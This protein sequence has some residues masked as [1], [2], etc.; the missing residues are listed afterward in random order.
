VDASGASALSALA[1][2]AL[3]GLR[4]V[5]GL[6]RRE[7]RRATRLG[8]IP[9]A[10]SRPARAKPVVRPAAQLRIAPVP[11]EPQDE[12]PATIE[13][14]QRLFVRAARVVAA[15]QYA[16]T[17]MVQR[18]LRTSGVMAARLMLALEA[19]GVLGPRAG[20]GVRVLVKPA[21]LDAVF[22]R[23]GIVTDA[24]PPGAEPH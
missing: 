7:R 15:A 17:T 14:P 10:V 19:A 3:L 5:I 16:S 4:I 22:A 2:V 24:L 8:R 13:V 21:D 23:F 9:R 11:A 6:D 20:G 18:R 12:A 1:A